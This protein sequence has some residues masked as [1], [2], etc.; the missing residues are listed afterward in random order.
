MGNPVVDHSVEVASGAAKA[1]PPVAVSGLTIYGVELSDIVL[2]ATLVYTLVQLFLVMPR[3]WG[4]ITK[5][6]RGKENVRTSDP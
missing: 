3:F 6:F 1:A 4:L 5:P 2:I